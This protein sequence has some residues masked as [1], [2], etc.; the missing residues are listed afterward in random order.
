MNTPEHNDLATAEQLAAQMTREFGDWVPV[1]SPVQLIP[2]SDSLESARKHSPNSAKRLSVWQSD[3][4]NISFCGA[5]RIVQ[6]S[7]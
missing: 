6:K 4:Q 7:A 3:T 2:N 1:S 5:R